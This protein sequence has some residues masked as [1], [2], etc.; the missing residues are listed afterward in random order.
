[1]RIIAGTYRRR[2]LLSPRGF[3]TR[4]IPDRV[5]ES[6]FGMLGQ[7]VEAAQVVDLFAGSG[8]VGLEA[9]SR[10][11]A[12]CLFVERDRQAADVLRRNIEL[13]GCADRAT[14]VLGDALGLSVTAR[15]PRPL[16]LAFVDPPYPMSTDQPTWLRIRA[17]CAALARLLA[18][19]G[20]LLVR[21]PWPFRM[22]RP[23]PEQPAAGFGLGSARAGAPAADAPPGRSGGRRWSTGRSARTPEPFRWDA[24]ARSGRR[25]ARSEDDE[26]PATGAAH[27]AGEGLAPERVER[28]GTPLS[29]EEVAAMLARDAE[30]L[31]PH[32][33]DAPDRSPGPVLG[34][35][36]IEGCRGPETHAYGRT[37]VHW[38]MRST[39]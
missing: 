21:T 32:G 1:M 13:L 17:Q 27:D 2:T 25:R 34:D 22:N 16:D 38:Y 35:L 4:P 33:A 3:T 11:A 37:A 39:G 36:T 29:P 23:E 12:G 10:G 6:V 5:K 19:D 31:H 28:F 26:D 9:L 14:V 24:P 30:R 7:R 15:C 20:F 8:S 18:P